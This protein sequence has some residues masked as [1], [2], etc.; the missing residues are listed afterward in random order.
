MTAYSQKNPTSG[1]PDCICRNTMNLHPAETVAHAHDHH[2]VL[3]KHLADAIVSAGR[4]HGVLSFY[5]CKYNKFFQFGYYLP[6]KFR[7]RI[8]NSVLIFCCFGIRWEIL[9]CVS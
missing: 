5:G 7:W 2:H 4:V 3:M 6:E 1:K 8:Q 9:L